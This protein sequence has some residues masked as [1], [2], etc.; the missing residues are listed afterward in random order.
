ME[1]DIRIFET[2][3]ELA[4]VFAK[5]L[6]SMAQDFQNQKRIMYVALSGGNTPK[7]L[8]HLLARDFAEAMP[9]SNLHFFWGDERCVPSD[10]SESNYGMSLE[11]LFSRIDIPFE[12]IHRIR[13]E[14]DPKIEVQRY[15]SEINSVLPRENKMPRFDLIILGL[16]EDG[17]TASIFP[18]QM[19]IL[20]SD[21]TCEIAVHPQSGQKRISLTGRVINSAG[22]IVF[23]VTGSNKSRIARS[24]INERKRFFP[25]AH[26][27]PVNGKLSWLL[28]KS[29]ARGL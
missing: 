3:L 23:M 14:A 29:V 6:V 15:A 10:N 9:W 25:A 7:I 18:N 24:V 26:I 11:C 16:G 13:G 5:E 28:D 12:N 27:K 22:W 2:P 4:S 1:A 8:F 19:D 20:Q 17:H 21:N